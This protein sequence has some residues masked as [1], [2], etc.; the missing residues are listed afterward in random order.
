MRNFI[1]SLS[2]ASLLL[3]ACKKENSTKV[4]YNVSAQKNN[5]AWVAKNPY[6]GF[7]NANSKDSVLIIAHAGEETLEIKFKSKGA[8]T[9]LQPDLNAYYYT[10]IG[11]D[12]VISEYKLSNTPTNKLIIN[13]YDEGNNIITGQFNL[14]FQKLRDDNKYSPDNIVFTNGI[15]NA[16]V[17][18]V[19]PIY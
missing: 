13:S 17:H 18:Y 12:V 8:G 1:L 3:F 19:K 4:Q 10:T 15:L 6:T 14:T 2:I 9:Y 7:V 11:F 16:P 5:A